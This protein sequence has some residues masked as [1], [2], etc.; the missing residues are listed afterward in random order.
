MIFDNKES[1]T[2]LVEKMMIREEYYTEITDEKVNVLIITEENYLARRI[3]LALSNRR[4]LIV[5]I[6]WQ[7]INNKSLTAIKYI[8]IWI[9]KLINVKFIFKIM[10]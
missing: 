5:L 1:L 8:I 10:N 4:Y 2:D 6:L 9:N 3:S 7:F